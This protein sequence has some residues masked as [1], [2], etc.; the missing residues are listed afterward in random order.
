[1]RTAREI[2]EEIEAR[3]G[4]FPPFFVPAEDNPQVLENLWQQTLQA[5]VENP[6]PVLFREKLF[7]WLSRYCVVPYCIVCHS[8]ALRPLGMK[9]SQVL[10]LLEALPPAHGAIDEALARMEAL[11][12]AP[13]D[14]PAPG[15]ALEEDLF[16]CTVFLFVHQAQA[17]RCR[18][19]VRRLLSPALYEHLTAFL[20]Y[21]K[22]CH[23]WVEAHPELSY[24]ADLRAREYLGPL[25]REEPRLGD[26]FAHY[27]ERVR[28]ER[29]QRERE[30]LE[31][32]E[33]GQRA[34]ALSETLSQ[35]AR[36]LRESEAHLR[37]ALESAALG[38]W[39][40][41][42]RTGELYWDARCKALMGL[43]ED[44][45]VELDY[46][47]FLSTIH[48]EDRAGV[49]ASV[50]RALAPGGG[51]RVQRGVPQPGTAGWRGAVARRAGPLLLRRPGPPRAL[52]RHGDGCHRAPAHGGQ[53]ALPRRGQRAAGRLARLRGHPAARG[54][55][56]R[57]R[58]R[59][60]VRGGRG[61]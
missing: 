58:A 10:E 13:R 17:E 44:E 45:A 56:G 36:A 23:L 37:L 16:R 5:Y 34:Q 48:P 47:T 20:A 7:A 41:K 1:M 29:E 51:R 14:W 49:D 32:A 60:L 55:P 59:R 31:A 42:P 38:T 9:S 26:F 11:G 52:P 50:Q 46:D 30:L 21:V 19:R 3:F 22:T 24:E 28:T 27:G 18:E 25:L 35:Q 4:F 8:C 54:Q 43:P 12:N 6:L 39:D 61:G 2:R 15:S 57:A 40:F 33:A 53:P